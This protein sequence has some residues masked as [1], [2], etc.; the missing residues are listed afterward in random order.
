MTVLVLIIGALVIYG[1]QTWT[2][3]NVFSCEMN[4]R[5]SSHLVEPE[6]SF[7][8]IITIR[9]KTRHFVP[10]LRYHISLPKGIRTVEESGSYQSSTFKN[11]I[12]DHTTWLKPA[13][14]LEV[15]IPVC[16]QA[17]GRYQIQDVQLGYGDFL[18]LQEEIV[19][20]GLVE[21]IVAYP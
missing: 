14:I 18:G 2:L 5:C 8:L 6:E 11:Y 1:V 3:R 9:N 21:E 13:Q 17:R 15:H 7:E 19:H 12:I 10:F 16:C 20:V 4:L